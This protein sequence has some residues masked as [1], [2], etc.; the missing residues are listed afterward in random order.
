IQNHKLIAGGARESIFQPEWSPAGILHF[1]SDRTGW[2][3]IY[4]TAHG[5]VECLH[6]MD[7]EFAAPQWVFGLST[8]A[9][10]SAD[11]IIC[12]F[13][14]KGNW[15]LGRIDTRTKQFDR[16]KT[17]FTEISFVHA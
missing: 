2:W 16:V 1:A 9:F 4:R 7:D 8:Y 17:S 13:V 3:N 10:E 12:A 5:V 14:E 11:K 15:K 6:E